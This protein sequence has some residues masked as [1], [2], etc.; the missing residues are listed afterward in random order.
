MQ[1]WGTECYHRSHKLTNVVWKLSLT[2]R[3]ISWLEC[4]HTHKWSLHPNTQKLKKMFFKSHRHI[5]FSEFK[6]TKLIT[7]RQI[8]QLRRIMSNIIERILPLHC[9]SSPAR[10]QVKKTRCPPLRRLAK[11]PIHGQSVGKSTYYSFVRP[12]SFC[13]LKEE[14]N[15]KL[16]FL[17]EI[18]SSF[19][20]TFAN[21]TVAQTKTCH[22]WGLLRF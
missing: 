7:I 16:C 14:F 5:N 21:S 22:S 11:S 13:L 15:F 20:L 6:V 12:F 19:I 1:A 10:P 8:Y 17:Q 4:I 18:S 2:F 9:H 3:L